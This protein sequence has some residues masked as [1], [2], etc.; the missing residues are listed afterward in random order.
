VLDVQEDRPRVANATK[1]WYYF[2]DKST[3]RA[4]LNYEN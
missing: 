3:F 2:F 4:L 1:W